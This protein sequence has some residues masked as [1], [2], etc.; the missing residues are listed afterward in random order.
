M[1]LS[2]FIPSAIKQPIKSWY[3]SHLLG[4]G[5][6]KLRQGDASDETLTLMRT[7]WANDGWDA[8]PVFLRELIAALAMTS[9]SVVECGSGLSTLVMAAVAPDRRRISFEHYSPWAE[10]V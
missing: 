3:A 10:R 6:E 7:G 8:K 9:G 4:S 5:L 2:R 1:I